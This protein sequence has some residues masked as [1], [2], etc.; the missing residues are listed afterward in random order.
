MAEAKL[1]ISDIDCAACVRRVRRA[2]EACPGVE[3][4]QVSYASG[5]AEI[6]YDE[7]RTDLEGIVKCVKNAGFGVPT[8]TA[9]IKC[10]DPVAAEATL[11]MLDCVA[12]F[13]RDEKSGAIKA[14]LWPIGADEVYMARALGMPAEVRIT[15]AEENG[16]DRVKQTELLRGI[17]AA[18]F[19]SLPQ[20]WDISFAARLI[21]GAL[22]LFAGAYF[23]R[24]S[25]RAIRKKVLSPDIAAAV[26]LTAVYV[27]CAVDIT[28]FPLLTA[29]TV[30]L[31]LSRYAE[32]RAAYALGASARRLLHMQPK[33]ARVL[34]NGQIAE[35][36][37]YE[38]CTGDIVVA[39]PG[40]R[41]AADGEIVF[42]ECTV[43]ESAL[44]GDRELVC[45]SLGDAVLC[46]SLDRAGEVHMRVV[47]AGKDTVLQGKISE[48]GSA[49][50]PRAVSRIAAALGMTAVFALL[51][52]GKD[53][54]K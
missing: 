32:R 14:Q 40:E 37:I 45:K 26:I 12:F 47:S 11:H 52:C 27:L 19:F 5:M 16:G 6:C 51:F 13:E 4:A 15:S 18:V 39:L 10:E 24:A 2:L 3:S 7:G 34:Q 30:L 43:D 29:A 49:E 17:F 28:H 21:F 41:I 44:T 48:L 50:P 25:A 38:L 53:G 42:G 36:S 9:L 31:L 35:K 20:L 33:T 23:Y 46:G 22:T 54:E 1:K 8:D